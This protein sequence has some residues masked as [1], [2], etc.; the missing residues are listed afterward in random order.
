MA[1]LPLTHNSFPA[2]AGA[3]A[4]T[5]GEE[6]RQREGSGWDRWRASAVVAP[7][8]E[9]RPAPIPEAQ[10]PA[11]ALRPVL[12]PA[13]PFLVVWHLYGHI[14]GVL[15]TPCQLLAADSRQ[16]KGLD[17][18]FAKWMGQGRKGCWLWTCYECEETIWTFG[19]KRKWSSD[20]PASDLPLPGA[21]LTKMVPTPGSQANQVRGGCL[22]GSPC[23][24]NCVQSEPQQTSYYLLYLS[25]WGLSL[26][27]CWSVGLGICWMSQ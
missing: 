1:P 18:K 10:P 3:R 13:P 6:V 20:R 5:E 15:R 11:R 27:R 17:P 14:C 16:T 9:P 12:G 21:V 4:T 7:R 24:V 26:N 23:S 19:S 8:T 22:S 2:D 25:V